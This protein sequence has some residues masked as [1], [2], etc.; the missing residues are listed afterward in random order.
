MGPN[1]RGADKPVISSKKQLQWLSWG[2]KTWSSCPSLIV[3]VRSYWV[4]PDMHQVQEWFR[5]EDRPPKRITHDANSGWL[6]RLSG[7][8][9]S[10]Y[11]LFAT[12]RIVIAFSS[13]DRK[14][15]LSALPLISISGR[16]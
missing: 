10:L 16:G 1:K 5:M 11:S 6:E 15:R 4:P 14:A 13:R 2:P 7:L 8:D 9:G 3:Y 12:W